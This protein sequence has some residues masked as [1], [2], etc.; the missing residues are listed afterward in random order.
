MRIVTGI[1]HGCIRWAERTDLNETRMRSDCTGNRTVGRLHG[2]YVTSAEREG[3]ADG[4]AERQSLARRN[5]S[6]GA[7]VKRPVHGE[8]RR[9]CGAWVHTNSQ[10]EP[11]GERPHVGRR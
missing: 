10:E 7:G 9:Y 4:Y 5:N 1:E 2:A 3:L 8:T 11:I 6:S